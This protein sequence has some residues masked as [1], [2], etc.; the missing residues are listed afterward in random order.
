MKCIRCDT[1]TI[2]GGDHDLDDD[3]EYYLE[4]NFTCPECDMFYLVFTP[5]E[6]EA[7]VGA[8]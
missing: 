3:A 4:S 8:A 6:P 5:H 7:D 1:E 2:H